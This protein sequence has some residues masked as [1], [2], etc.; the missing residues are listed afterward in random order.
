MIRILIVATAATLIGLTA[1]ACQ[2]GTQSVGPAPATSTRAAALP[3]PTTSTTTTR[4]T[5]ATEPAPA[6]DARP[7][8]TLK[9]PNTTEDVVFVKYDWQHKLA[10]FQKVVQDPT[11]LAANLVPD[12]RDPGIH[13]LPVRPGTNVKSIDPRGF[14]F[15]TCP[16]TSCTTADVM[17][18]VIGH[19]RGAFWAH[20]QVNAADQIDLVAQSAY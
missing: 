19:Y 14:P 12:P 13:K 3:P 20:I 5:D 7:T 18:S 16:P 17:D 8:R 2:T 9:F 11:S 1:T 15:E 10:E 4:T 6:A